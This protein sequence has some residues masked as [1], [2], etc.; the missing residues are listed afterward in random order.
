MGYLHVQIL[1]GLLEKVSLSKLNLGKRKKRQVTALCKD[2]SQ[3]SRLR[4]FWELPRTGQHH[5]PTSCN[6]IVFCLETQ[7]FYAL[8]ETLRANIGGDLGP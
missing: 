2:I 7:A 3:L 1:P 8:S 6:E 5:L 4:L